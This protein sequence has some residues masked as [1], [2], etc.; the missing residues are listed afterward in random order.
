MRIEKVGIKNFKVYKDAEI[1]DLSNFCFFLGANG[2][3]K[4][5]L[6]EVFGFLSDARK[7]N[8]KVDLNKRGGYKEVYS[9]EREGNMGFEI[10]FRNPGIDG[11]KQP[12]NL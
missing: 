12:H 2:S 10:K 1:G 11:L 8:V 5:T 6:F 4:S 9:R 3:G 7:S